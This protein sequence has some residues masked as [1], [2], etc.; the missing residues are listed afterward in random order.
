MTIEAS[1]TCPAFNTVQSPPNFSSTNPFCGKR[2]KLNRTQSLE[3]VFYPSREYA[4]RP[5]A[6]KLRQ[7][8]V[9][10][11]APF[12]SYKDW[13]KLIPPNY[14]D[15]ILM[16]KLNIEPSRVDCQLGS[17]AAGY[18]ERWQDSKKNQYAVKFIKNDDSQGFNRFEK[19]EVLSQLLSGIDGVVKTYAI[20]LQNCL[21]S[22]CCLIRSRDQWPLES[23][24]NF[25]VKAIVNQLIDGPDLIDHLNALSEPSHLQQRL[26]L[27]ANLGATLCSILS[28]IHSFGIVHCDLKPENILIDT[29]EEKIYLCD[30]GF[31]QMLNLRDRAKGDCGTPNYIAPEIF[32]V[33]LQKRSGYQDSVDNFS[34]GMLLLAASTLIMTV[35]ADL[36]PPRQ[37]NQILKFAQLSDQGKRRK[38]NRAAPEAYQRCPEMF[39]VITGLTRLDPDKRMSLD[40]AEMKLRLIA[41][42]L[43]KKVITNAATPKQ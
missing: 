37:L 10:V 17:G 31:A 4:V 18:V 38:F 27:T 29:K 7:M 2:T 12:S 3:S 36:P 9:A 15:L 1:F 23:S 14:H 13:G 5:P 22:E 28:D 24:E 16:D 40:D 39:D 21:T 33:N 8:A 25:R 41:Y 43:K 11:N 34:L 35:D 20:L 32:A 6:T 26:L 30:F 42:N 19:G